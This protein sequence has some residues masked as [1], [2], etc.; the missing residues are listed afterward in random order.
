MR[1][2]N[3]DI[4]SYGVQ[5]P[6]WHMEL[7]TQTQFKPGAMLLFVDLFYNNKVQEWDTMAAKEG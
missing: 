2:M 5:L 6:Y 4:L 1:Y 3:V 7:L